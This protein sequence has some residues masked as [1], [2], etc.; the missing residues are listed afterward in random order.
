MK[1]K[2]ALAQDFLSNLSSLP[3]NVQAKVLKWALRFQT[4]PTSSGINYETIRA[5]RDK[6]LRS[7][8]IDQDWRGIVFKPDKG[9]V[10]VLMYVDKHDEAYSWAENR[11][12]AINP[13]TGA[14]QV[15]AVESLIEPALE[16]VRHEAEETIAKGKAGPSA[17]PPA[18]PA[19]LYKGLTDQ[20]LISIGTPE[21]TIPQVRT[22]RTEAELDALQQFLPIEAY[23]G[24]FLIAAGDTV[25][26]VLVSRE[27]RIDKK[28]DTGDFAAALDTAE[29]QARFVVVDDNETMAAIL[30]APL[31]QWRVFLH[32]TQR[33]LAQSDRSG[34]MRVLGG[35][36]TGK[37]V[38]AMHRAKWIADNRA[39]AESKV[40]VTTFTK[41][42]AQDIEDNLKTLCSQATMQKIEVQNL[43]AWVHAYLRK[44][45]YEYTIIF[46]RKQGPA[47]EAWGLALSLADSSLA[48][49]PGF[50]EE[51]FERVI[52]AQGVT[53]QDEYRQAK[54][55]GRGTVLTRSKRDAIWPVFEEYRAALTSR[56]LKEV[57]DAYRDAAALLRNTPT[58]FCS[59]IVDETQ[60]FGP[61]ALKLLRAMV[62]SGPND[63]F[64]VGDGHQRI[65]NRNRASMSA[66]GID[67]RG[68]ARK[69]YLN[70]RTTEEIRKVAVAMLE[71]C[72]VDDLDEGSDEIKKYKSVSRGPQPT[73]KDVQH[74]ENAFAQTAVLVDE[75]LKEGRSICVMV[76]SKNDA[77]EVHSVLRKAGMDA[78]IIGAKERDRA[79]SKAARVATMHRA[80]G[81]EFDEVVLIVPKLKV[82]EDAT[83]SD[84]RKL[85]YVAITRAKR[86]A[87][88]FRCG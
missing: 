81:L 29:S 1:P 75:A 17:K 4:D 62:R 61:Q 39:S 9:D 87:T 70:Y 71:G 34:P 76:P 66:C 10:Y 65:Y 54:R 77:A 23:E 36:G 14:M 26:D 45:K 63:L 80:K 59:I 74:K 48:L 38:L 2:V 67:I 25:S 68:R 30:N 85:H 31:A 22:I 27:T 12:I 42:L 83:V 46:N 51:E 7:V 3:A 28:I 72:E 53:T 11:R 33:K 69:L 52:L 73:M 64:F 8:R 43:D 13:V 15:F 37:T 57:E 50:Y 55:T 24:L 41:N 84:Q 60:D 56:K 21:D 86:K 78:T 5:A 88:V 32:P 16:Q 79:D 35:A 44:N 6:N 58:S 82:S 49:P 18:Q 20:E 19:P 40:F 47:A